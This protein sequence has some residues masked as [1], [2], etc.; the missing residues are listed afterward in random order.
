[1]KTDYVDVS[2]TK[3]NLTIE[4]PSEE[5]DAQIDRVTRG[6]A[7]S[8][9]IPGFRP[10]KVPASIIKQRFKDQILQDVAR[11]MVPRA[12]DQALQQHGVEPVDSP[13]IQDFAID[14]GQP[15]KFTAVFETVPSFDPGDISEIILRQPP[16]TIDDEAVD[17]ALQRLRERAAR[18]EP[19]EGRPIAD[20]DTIVLDIER[21]DPDGKSEKHEQVPV[22]LGGQGNPPGFDANLVGMSPGES[23]SFVTHFPADY[24][25]PEMQNTDVSYHV[26]VKEVRQRVLPELDDEFAKDLGEFE[27]LAALRERVTHDLRHEAEHASQRQVRNDLLKQLAARIPFELPA[28]LLDRE[29]DRRVEEFARRLMEQ[30]ID[31]REANIDWAEVREAQREPARDAVASA[32]VLDE[33]SRRESLTPGPEAL[34]KEIGALAER[35]G[36]TPAAVKAQLE[37]DG[38]MSR[39]YT[40]LRREMA[41]DFAMGRAKITR[42]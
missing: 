32:I 9:R 22:T 3:K 40:G 27:T 17:K 24:V 2:E 10:G 21:T 23:K 1:M 35:F 11:E 41:V 18:Y 5:V 7:K 15:L 38:S 4:I 29:M 33:V 13:D 14:E 39:I 28:G 19:V 34:D 26:S 8:A 37:K 36:R 16:A 12:V 42:V 31:P 25:V 6:Y 30:K 20:G